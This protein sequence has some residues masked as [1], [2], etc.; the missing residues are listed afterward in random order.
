[1]SMSHGLTYF[2]ATVL[3]I[4]C[5]GGGATETPDASPEE[6][7]VCNPLAGGSCL[8]PWPSSAYLDS[9]SSTVTG[10]RVVLPAEAMPVNI[11]DIRVD[12]A[13]FSRYDGFAA[14]A[15]IVVGFPTGVS[16]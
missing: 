4:G 12:P 8:L 14:S 7:Q 16:P 3:T 2:L 9:D 13:P 5:G 10:Y 11:D 6:P 15:V 1:M